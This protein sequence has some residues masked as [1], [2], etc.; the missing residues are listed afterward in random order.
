[1]TDPLLA[2]EHALGQLTT[3]GLLQVLAAAEAMQPQVGGGGGS[4]AIGECLSNLEQRQ[5]LRLLE[6]GCDPDNL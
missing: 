2:L 4:L 6:V 1:M 5:L 3:G